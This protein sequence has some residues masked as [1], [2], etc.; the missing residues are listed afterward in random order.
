MHTDV[1]N[2]PAACIFKIKAFYDEKEEE[3]S[4]FEVFTGMCLSTMFWYMKPRHWIIVFSVSEG[5]YYLRKIGKRLI[6][7]AASYPRKNEKS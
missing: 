4:D 2:E 5:I 3:Y 1:Y 6:S 7:E